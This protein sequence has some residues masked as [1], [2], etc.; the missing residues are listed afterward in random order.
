[1]S[2]FKSLHKKRMFFLLHIKTHK[3]F[4]KILGVQCKIPSQICTAQL[5]NKAQNAV[6]CAVQICQMRLISVLK[7]I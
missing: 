1:M 2:A 7:N 5:K 4:P 6:L 3:G